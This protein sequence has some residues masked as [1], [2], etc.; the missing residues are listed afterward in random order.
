VGAGSPSNTMSLGSRPTFLPSAILIHRAIW[1]QQIWAE[2]WGGGPG[3]LS[4]T[5]WPGPRPTCMPSFVLI[6]P[7][8]WPPQTWTENWGVCPLFGE[9]E[10]GPHLGQRGLGWDLPPYQVGAGSPSN[11]M[12]LGSRP[13][14]LPSAILIHRAIG[15]QQI[16]AENW[17][18][19]L[20]F[21]LTQRGQGRGLPAC[22]V[23]SRS[24]QPF[25]H[26]TLTLQTG[27]DRSETDNG[28]I[29]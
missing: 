5:M 18:G 19:D 2:N 15:P 28:P 1:P 16:W 22:Q 8:V 10:L 13:T 11:T 4:N 7:A 6:H 23:S 9:R 29:S 12:S 25:G 21:H 14:F 26:N 3:F 17:G 20:G 24:V 27:H